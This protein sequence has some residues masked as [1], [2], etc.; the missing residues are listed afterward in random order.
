MRVLQ[1]SHPFAEAREEMMGLTLTENHP[2]RTAPTSSGEGETPTAHSHLGESSSPPLLLGGGHG[3]LSSPS[4]S[5][6]LGH[7]L[8]TEMRCLV[9]SQDGF[10]ANFSTSPLKGGLHLALLWSHLWA[11]R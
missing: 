5:S 8:P 1:G 11:G 3:E 4:L 6:F 9:R 2:N 7:Q 10:M